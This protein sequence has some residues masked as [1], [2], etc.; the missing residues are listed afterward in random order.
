MRVRVRVV[1]V[2]RVDV[3]APYEAEAPL[4]GDASEG[5]LAKARRVCGRWLR[6]GSQRGWAVVV[7]GS[8]RIPSGWTRQTTPERRPLVLRARMDTSGG[9]RHM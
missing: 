5:D 6:G 1:R 8:S 4:S 3:V 9:G 2:V 7:Q